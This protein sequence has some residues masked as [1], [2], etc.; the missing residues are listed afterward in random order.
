[1]VRRSV[2]FFDRS[3][4]ARR[5]V[6]CDRRPSDLEECFETKRSREIFNDFISQ[7]GVG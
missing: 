6:R 3:K 4:S 1:M 7:I 2:R 5:I